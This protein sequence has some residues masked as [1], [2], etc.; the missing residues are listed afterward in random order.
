MTAGEFSSLGESHRAR[1]P[2]RGPL[3]APPRLQLTACPR[4]CV[5]ARLCAAAS[6]SALHGYRGRRD[7]VPL[8]EGQRRR[9]LVHHDARRAACVPRPR[10]RLANGAQ[11]NQARRAG[12]QLPRRVPARTGAS[13]AARSWRV[14][15]RAH[16]ARVCLGA[17]RVPAGRAC[18]C[19]LL[20]ATC[21]C[22]L[23]FCL[24][25]LTRVRS[26][27]TC[28]RARRAQTSN[29]EAVSFYKKLGF[30]VRETVKGYYK[31]LDPPDAYLI[32]RPIT[33]TPKPEDCRA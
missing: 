26:L 2:A 20:T 9:A 25:G 31:R 16:A 28:A 5:T 1:G 11:C 6:L 22:A 32:A 4:S 23:L 24:R 17:V 10:R 8:R 13:A 19:T 33:H 27:R 7:R 3:R 29:D 15:T 12:S 21:V 30:E 18:H 14:E